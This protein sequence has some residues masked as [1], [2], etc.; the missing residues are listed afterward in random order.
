METVNSHNPKPP[1]AQE[2]KSSCYKLT[3]SKNVICKIP[4]KIYHQNI[5]G[6][7]ANFNKSFH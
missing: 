5:R 7:K 4:L 2:T 3:K 6:F 1:I